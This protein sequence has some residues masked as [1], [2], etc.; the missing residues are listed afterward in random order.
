MKLA[1]MPLNSVLF[2]WMPVTLSIYEQ[3]YLDMLR[4]VLDGARVFG[5]ALI[6]EGKEVG[7]PAV[8][9]RVGTEVMVAKAWETDDGSWRIVGVGR[10]RFEIADV[11]GQDPY[12]IAEV[13]YR[14]W[15]EIDEAPPELV[16]QVRRLFREHLALLT[17]LLGI[18]GAELTIPDS[19]ARLSY[20]VAAHLGVTLQER[21][22]LLEIRTPAERL[23]AELELLRQDVDKMKIF[24][25]A[26]KHDPPDERLN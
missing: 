22:R 2:P 23:E 9:H 11:V 12:P 14:G 6:A 16:D 3:R 8:P 4:D 18:G 10:H 1:L 21:Q 19:P 5:V 17:E 26:G 20:M 25:A 24:S 7:G 13:E 15:H